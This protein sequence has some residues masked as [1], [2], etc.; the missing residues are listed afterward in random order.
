MEA[1]WQKDPKD[2]LSFKQI[3]AKLDKI[4]GKLIS[5]QFIICFN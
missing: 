3:L 2:R 4:G 5:N 1:C